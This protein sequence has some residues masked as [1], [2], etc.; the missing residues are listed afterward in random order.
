MANA[1]VIFVFGSVL[2]RTYY[3]VH[4]DPLGRTT[5]RVEQCQWME[6]QAPAFGIVHNTIQRGRMDY[7]KRQISI[8]RHSESSFSI[9][10]AAMVWSM[11]H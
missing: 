3:C 9:V 1:T 5:S 7:H 11:F 6:K 2:P 8:G 10:A 4:K